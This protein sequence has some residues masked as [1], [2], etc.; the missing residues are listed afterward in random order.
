MV[1]ITTQ[2][3]PSQKEVNTLVKRLVTHIQNTTPAPIDR[4]RLSSVNVFVIFSPVPDEIPWLID[5][6][7]KVFAEDEL[8]ET[9]DE[10]LFAKPTK[11]TRT[12]RATKP[13]AQTLNTKFVSLRLIPRDPT[14][15]TSSYWDPVPAKDMQSSNETRVYGVID[16]YLLTLP[17]TDFNQ[18][19]AKTPEPLEPSFL[20]RWFNNNRKAL[21]LTLPKLDSPSKLLAVKVANAENPALLKSKDFQLIWDYIQQTFRQA[22]KDRTLNTDRLLANLMLAESGNNASY[23]FKRLLELKHINTTPSVKALKYWVDHEEALKDDPVTEAWMTII[24]NFAFGNT[25]TQEGTGSGRLNLTTTHKGK[26]LFDMSG[27]K[28]PLTVEWN[29]LLSDMLV[30][31]VYAPDWLSVSGI[32]GGIYKDTNL[33]NRQTKFEL[34][35]RNLT[36]QL[37]YYVEFFKLHQAWPIDELNW[38]R[39]AHLSF[40]PDTANKF[41]K[42]Y[43][44]DK[45]NNLLFDV[46][47]VQR[48]LASE[49]RKSATKN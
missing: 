30:T 18:D 23:V 45:S 26:P 5:G 38:K 14:T 12:S 10:E 49:A 27:G 28:G 2:L 34:L 39:N 20:C 13:T 9:I 6:S 46:E 16:K 22:V 37:P 11:S 1:G 33:P 21:E 36:L 7:I 32:V 48:A 24:T 35:F 15:T 42:G 31:R 29:T 40:N 25:F 43:L 44:Q 19:G 4:S 8:P 47:T 41:S 3:K 17:E